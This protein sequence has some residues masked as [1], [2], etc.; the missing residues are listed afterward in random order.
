MPPSQNPKTKS[1][2]VIPKPGT[3]NTNGVIHAAPPPPSANS[4]APHIDPQ[5]PTTG[6]AYYDKLRK[7]LRDLIARKKAVDKSLVRICQLRNPPLFL[8]SSP[9]ASSS[10]TTASSSRGACE[11]DSWSYFRSCAS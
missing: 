9:S 7:E 1:N 6:L 4:N 2:P 8:C 3:I 11:G 10:S 5:N